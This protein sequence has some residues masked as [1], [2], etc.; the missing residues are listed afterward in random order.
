MVGKNT[1]L[2]TRRCGDFESR[3]GRRERSC[4]IKKSDNYLEKHRQG[5]DGVIL[6]KRDK[7]YALAR[8]RNP[9]RWSGNTRDWTLVGAVTLNP[10]KEDVKEA[11]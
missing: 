6:Q 11:A 8:S 3:E 2:G 9:A 4:L 10:E 7:L 5:E 1:R